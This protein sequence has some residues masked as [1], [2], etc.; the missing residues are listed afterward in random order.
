M[1]SLILVVGVAIFAIALGTYAKWIEKEWGIDPD[2]VTPAHSMKDGVDYVPAPKVVLFGHHFSSIAG[3][4]PV[5]G[6]ITASMF[7]WL[8]V[9]IWC[10]VACVFIGGVQ[11]FGTIFASV[12]HKGRSMGE[13]IKGYMG[14]TGKRLFAVFAFFTTILLVAAFLDIVAKTFVSTPSAGTSSLLFILLAV[15]YG[16]VTNKLRMPTSMATIFGVALV[17]LS[18]WAGVLWPLQLS[19]TTWILLLIGYV[20][21][22]STAPVWILLQPRDYLNSFLLYAMMVGAIVGAIIYN[23]TIQMPA[24]TGFVINDTPLFPILFVTL[25]CGAISGFHSLVGSGTTSKQINNQRDMRIVGYG[26]MLLEGVLALVALV[27]V[28][29]LVPAETAELRSAGPLAIF[30]HG[31][32]TFLTTFGLPFE[33]GMTFAALSLSAFAM[34]TLD[35]AVRLARFIVQE[36]GAGDKQVEEV[37]KTGGSLLCNRHV[38]TLVAVAIG[39]A[40]AFFGYAR[41]WPIFGSANQLLAS[42]A[43]LAMILWLRSIGKN[44]VMCVIPMFWMGVVC[45]LALAFNVYKYITSNLPLTIVA[46]LL[47]CVALILFKKGYESFFHNAKVL[48]SEA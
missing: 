11:D 30:S 36:F 10:I 37:E 2:R 41:I 23:P 48:A 34:T 15:L 33:L 26:G 29:Y 6:A 19:H 22:A 4:A 44:Y 3:A 13:V 14:V 21:I 17:F 16:L 38:S 18:I 46:L 45:T 39:G 12:R 27:T 43:L 24:F 20:Y 5:V 42:L 32:G 1:A 7:G 28:V 40:L 47:L 8:P 25:A 35:T 31:V 9:T